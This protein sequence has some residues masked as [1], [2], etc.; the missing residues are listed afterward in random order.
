MSLLGDLNIQSSIGMFTFYDLT[1][2]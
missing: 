1:F 2:L